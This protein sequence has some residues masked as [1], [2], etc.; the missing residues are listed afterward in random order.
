MVRQWQKIFYK[1]RFSASELT[2]HTPD[3]V[4]LAEAM[5]AVGLRLEQKSE[6]KDVFEKMLEINDMDGQINSLNVSV[7]T[8]IILYEAISQRS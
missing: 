1:N 2:H 3:Y 8:G 7:A 4:K 6:V 5:G